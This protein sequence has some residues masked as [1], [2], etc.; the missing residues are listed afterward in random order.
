MRV[1]IASY[2]STHGSMVFYLLLFALAVIV[3]AA[4]TAMPR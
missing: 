4:A 1:A 2:K 3:R